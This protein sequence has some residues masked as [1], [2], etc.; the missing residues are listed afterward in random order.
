VKGST[1]TTTKTKGGIMKRITTKDLEAIVV[2]LNT[3]TCN[4]QEPYSKDING[5]LRPNAGN[6]WIDQAYGGNKLVQMG[7]DSGTRDV[8]TIGYAPKRDLFDWIDAYI[9]GFLNHTNR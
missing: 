4:P 8:S 3:I 9:K 1:T 7:D 2:R 6:Y 5:R